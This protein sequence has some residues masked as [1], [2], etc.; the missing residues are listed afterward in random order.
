M[1]KMSFKIILPMLM[2]VVFF[3]VAQGMNWLIINNFYDQATTIISES[4]ASLE[5]QQA[6]DELLAWAREREVQGV[7]TMVAVSVIAFGIIFLKVVLPTKRVMKETAFLSA[8]LE[9]GQM[10]TSFRL[11]QTTQDEIG[12]LVA[13]INLFLERLSE[14]SYSLLESASDLKVSSAKVLEDVDGV[15]ASSTDI[16]ATMQE[17]AASMQELSNTVSSA[18]ED[19]NVIGDAAESMGADSKDIMGKVS[20][21]K[22][23]AAIMREEALKSKQETY[24]MI[25]AINGEL[26]EAIE[27]GKKV[28]LIEELAKEI[29]NI[30]S[31]T[32]LLALN[33]SIEAARAGDAGRGFAVVAE[34]IRQLA[35]SSRTTATTIQEIT[36]VVM[37]AVERLM[38]SSGKVMEYVNDSV[39]PDY[40]SRVADGD[41]YQADAEGIF[42][43]MTDFSGK[44][45]TLTSAVVHMLSIFDGIAAAIDQNTEGIT[46]AAENVS[47]LAISMSSV[48]NETEQNTYVADGLLDIVGQLKGNIE[49]M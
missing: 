38:E 17:L 28:V 23:R 3:F 10:D 31:Q 9:S 15:N 5:S 4:G 40:D 48:S 32:N 21:Q 41:Q 1:K 22:E 45:E 8:S 30:A 25:G 42:A 36:S 7:G 6:L 49:T 39:L 2:L 47:A 46:N 24:G 37:G 44:I 33:A 29:L 14:I 35:D 27:G 16:S 11:T 34:E 12:K 43:V 20:G 18:T 26:S 19:A 13:M